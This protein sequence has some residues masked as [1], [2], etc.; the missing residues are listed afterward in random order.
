[1]KHR[2][3]IVFA[4]TV[5]ACGGLLGYAYYLEIYAHL[6]PCPMCIFQRLCYA[7]IMV[8]AFIGAVHGPRRIG[9]Y[10]YG[11]F[12]LAAAVIGA[13][14]AARQVWLQHLP[15]D[16]V[17]ACGPGLDYML[18]AFPLAEAIKNALRGTGECALVDWTLL[19]LSM[20][21]WSLG[22]FAACAIAYLVFITHSARG[23]VS[24]F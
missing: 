7:A 16:R 12:I 23:A 5:L 9:I 10:A 14:I 8:I 22:C 6:E 3:R 11:G 2:A 24:S 18:E 20:A 1:M 19:G 13:A 15:A 17:P 4:A 21:E